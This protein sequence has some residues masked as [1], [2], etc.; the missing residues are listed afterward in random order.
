MDIN[1]KV[2]ENLKIRAFYVFFIVVSI[3]IGVGLIGF[4]RIVVME[5]LQDSWI[6]ILIAYAYI[7]CVLIAMLLILKQYDNSD[8]FGIH[9]DIFGKWIGKLIGTLFLIHFA[10]SMFSL[11]ITYIEIVRVFIF[12][13]ISIFVLSFLILCL[14]IYSVLGGIRVVVGVCT[15]FGIYSNWILFPL[16]QPALQMDFTH[17][18]PIFEA[19]FPDI[20]KGTKLSGYSF[21]GFEIIL[22]LYPYIK[23]K[24]KIKFPLFLAVSWTTLI[25][26]FV[27]IIVMGYLSFSEISTRE[28][29]LLSLYKIQRFSFIE[30]FDY[31]VVSS[32]MI[33]VISNMILLMWGITYGLKRMYKIPQKYTL[34]I[35]SFLILAASPFFYE[36]FLIQKVIDLS[37]QLGFWLVYIYPFI[38]LPIVLIKKRLIENRK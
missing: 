5:A 6:S 37:A 26:L 35:V 22:V 3:Q 23:N 34:Y 31:I 9:V 28:W 36:H 33:I 21:L 15:V 14:V 2:K 24:K 20:L 11:L 7:V 16:I 25:M 12:P 4:P 18:L 17:L 13:N 32:W 19:P 10:I 29:I 38:L 30:R 8:V 27:T 1:I